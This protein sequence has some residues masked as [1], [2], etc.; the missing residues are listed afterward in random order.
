[1]SETRKDQFAELSIMATQGTMAAALRRRLHR[2]G[3]VEAQEMIDIIEKG[4]HLTARDIG[5]FFWHLDFEPTF[6]VSDV[7]KQETPND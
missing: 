2:F 1:M 3:G 4:E 6:Q 5:E 7:E